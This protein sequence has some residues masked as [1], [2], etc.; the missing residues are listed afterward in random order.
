MKFKI[1][2]QDPSFINVIIVE[3][4]DFGGSL[5]SYMIK[6]EKDKMKE[7]MSSFTRET[8]FQEKIMMMKGSIIERRGSAKPFV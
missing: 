6:S 7:R 2:E 1:D 8:Q 5:P 4:I 3:R